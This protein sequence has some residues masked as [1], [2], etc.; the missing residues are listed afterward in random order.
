METNTQKVTPEYLKQSALKANTARE[1]NGLDSSLVVDLLPQS[2]K[3]QVARTF[4]TSD[5]T[6]LKWYYDLA[7][8]GMLG[9]RLAHLMALDAYGMIPNTSNISEL[10]LDDKVNRLCTTVQQMTN[11]LVRNQKMTESNMIAQAKS[12]KFLQ[13]VTLTVKSQGEILRAI[14]SVLVSENKYTP[15]QIRIVLDSI[16]KTIQQSVPIRPTSETD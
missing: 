13:N 15:E 9:D 8:K 14:E 7:S 5:A 2:H 1:G 10:S 11:M 3:I 4:D 6:V 16:K 12:I